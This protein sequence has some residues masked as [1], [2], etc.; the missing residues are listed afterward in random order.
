MYDANP[1][2][3]IGNVTVGLLNTLAIFNF[4]YRLLTDKYESV[5]VKLTIMNYLWLPLLEAMPM[6]VLSTITSFPMHA[7]GR[8]IMISQTVK[9]DNTSSV[10][11]SFIA[12]MQKNS[13]SA[14]MLDEQDIE[15]FYVT[16]QCAYVFVENVYSRCSL[17]DIKGPITKAYAGE[18]SLSHYERSLYFIIFFFIEQRRG[19]NWKRVNGDY[20]SVGIQTSAYRDRFVIFGTITIESI[21]T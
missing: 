7:D 8:N 16:L 19:C 3:G 14:G 9:V 6:E 10:V 13:P 4:C 15:S 5:K 20:M 11:S 18:E 17:F 12:I 2:G 21:I 1:A